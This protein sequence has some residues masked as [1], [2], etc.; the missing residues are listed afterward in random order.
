MINRIASPIKQLSKHA[1]KVKDGD[2]AFRNSVQTDDEVGVLAKQFNVML[3]RVENNV[4]DLEQ[5]VQERTQKLR[6][7][8]YHDDLTN[9]PN[10]TALLREI[11]KEEFSSLILLDIFAFDDICELYGYEVGNQTVLVVALMLKDYCA[12]YDGELY[13]THSDVFG[14][15]SRG[16][17]YNIDSFEEHVNR[18]NELFETTPIRIESF[19][20][21]FYITMNMGLSIC[22]E[23]PF[24]RANIALKHAKESNN[25][26]YIYNGDINPT[27]NIEATNYWR[28]MIR[29]SLE[30]D[31]VIPFFQ[32]IVNQC[33]EV[34]KY[35]TL[36]RLESRTEDGEIEYLSPFFF[37]DIARKTKQYTPLT[38]RIVTKALDMILQTDK[39][40]SINLSF[41]DI[42]TK[43]INTLLDQ[44]TDKIGANNCSCLVFEILES[45]VIEDYQILEKFITKFRSKGVKIAIDDFG[46]GYSNFEYVL[47]IQPDYLKIDGSLIKDIHTDEN[48]LALVK[49]IVTFSKT[50]NIALIAEFVHNEEVF[51]ICKS[52]GIDEFQGFYFGKPSP[53]L[54]EG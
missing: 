35:E 51:N 41:A 26:F 23:E 2:L 1:L 9:L 49:S 34:V 19:Q 48:A 4:S 17:V 10:K 53:K 27:E 13:H 6:H 40:I 12:R 29:E 45:E 36:M 31:W 44:L 47:T 21:E 46:T 5:R 38:E 24:K 22:Q 28:R 54:I 43:D 42:Q 11:D 20:L 25:F 52:L 39:M 7:Q 50:M 15:F 18:L 14:I 16:M 33:G 8:L 3:D 37:L 32:P 30:N